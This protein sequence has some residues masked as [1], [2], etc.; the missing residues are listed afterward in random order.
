MNWTKPGVGKRMLPR[1]H[2]NDHHLSITTGEVKLN[3]A[4]AIP[5]VKILVPLAGSIIA[6]TAGATFWV[7]VKFNSFA[8]GAEYQQTKTDVAVMRADA[9]SMKADLRDLKKDVKDHG[10]KL[11]KILQKLDDL[12][13]SKSTMIIEERT[14]RGK[15]HP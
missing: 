1:G 7:A 14:I 2:V 9:G 10:E 4:R 12:S 3:M 5:L 8:N 6:A 11:D 15:R 13:T